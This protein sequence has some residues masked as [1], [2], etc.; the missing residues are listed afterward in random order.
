M[1]SAV[2]ALVSAAIHAGWSALI[3]HS[4]DPMVFTVIGVAMISFF[5]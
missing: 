1:T 5:D 4:G 3:K 2:L